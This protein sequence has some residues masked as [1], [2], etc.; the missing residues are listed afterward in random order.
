MKIKRH[1]FAFFAGMLIV[2]VTL[3]A[4]PADKTSYQPG[5][6]PLDKGKVAKVFPSE[7]AYSPYANRSFPSQ[8]LFGDTHLHTSLQERAYTSPI[9]YTP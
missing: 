2:C 6:P 7:P 1:L 4:I 3:P 8:P 5:L 9:W